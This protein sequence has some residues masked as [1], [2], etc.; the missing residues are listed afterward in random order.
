[1]VNKCCVKG[2]IVPSSTYEYTHLKTGLRTPC[3][4]GVGVGL[5][6][7]LRIRSVT[8]DYSVC[9]RGCWVESADGVWYRL[10]EPESWKGK[11]VYMG[12]LSVLGDVSDVLWCVDVMR[13]GIEDVRRGVGWDVLRREGAFLLKWLKVRGGVG[14]PKQRR[15]G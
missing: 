6:V 12:R 11:D 5:P 3:G 8:F 15:R 7:G 13:V 2:Y 9:L 1:M 14:H 4:V 10:C